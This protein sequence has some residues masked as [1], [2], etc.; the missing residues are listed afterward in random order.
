MKLTK[1]FYIFY[2]TFVLKSIVDHVNKIEE[3]RFFKEILNYICLDIE[4]PIKRWLVD[5][6][7]NSRQ[8]II[9]ER[10]RESKRAR[11]NIRPTVTWINVKSLLMEA[12][13]NGGQEKILTVVGI[14]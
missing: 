12:T 1:C 2:K 4:T 8:H 7:R 10:R 6:D 13:G 5:G 3:A 14:V 11:N 9:L